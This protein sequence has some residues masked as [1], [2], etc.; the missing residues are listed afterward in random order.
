VCVRPAKIHTCNY[1]HSTGKYKPF[2]NGD[3]K[4]VVPFDTELCEMRV[5]TETAGLVSST[6]L[7]LIGTPMKRV[8][9]RPQSIGRS[10]T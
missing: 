10:I 3:L 7:I 8:F 6:I 4:R 5:K 9:E 1:Y 2:T